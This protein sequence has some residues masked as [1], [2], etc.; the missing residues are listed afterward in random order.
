MGRQIR[1]DS[2]L[3]SLAKRMGLKKSPFYNK[4]GRKIRKDKTIAAFRKDE[5][6]K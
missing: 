3:D 5:K 2:T 1:D 6:K 4:N